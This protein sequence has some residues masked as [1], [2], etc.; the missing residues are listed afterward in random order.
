M[1]WD[2]IYEAADGKAC[3]EWEL[4]RK[5]IAR[6][7]VVCFVEDNF[8]INLETEYSQSIDKYSKNDIKQIN[9][10]LLNKPLKSLDSYTPKEAFIKVFDEEGKIVD[11]FLVEDEIADISSEDLKE[12]C[13]SAAGIDNN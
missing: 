9:Y 7:E 6:Y 8:G 2:E 13:N 11:R 12:W 1:T 4:K 5:D 3:G 10:T